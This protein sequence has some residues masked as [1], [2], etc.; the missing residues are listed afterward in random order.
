ME[1][2]ELEIELPMVLEANNKGVV[3][4]A[5][6]VLT[7]GRIKDMEIMKMWLCEL[8]DKGFFHVE[9]ISG[10]D[11]ET[12]IQTKIFVIYCFINMVNFIVVM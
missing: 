9:W 1:S 10:D 5:Q 4:I 8:E 7:S 3:D 6:N 2:I 11:N 12:N